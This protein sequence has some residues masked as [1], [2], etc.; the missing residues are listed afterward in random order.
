MEDMADMVVG[1]VAKAVP[2]VAE[3]VVKA[4]P[5]APV[6]VLVDARAASANFSAKRKSASSV[7]KRS[8]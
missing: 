7:S 2:G 8:I 4:A 6:A 5:A 3:D 1:D